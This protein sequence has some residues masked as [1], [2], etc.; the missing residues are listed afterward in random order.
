MSAPVAALLGV[1]LGGLLS[2]TTTYLLERRRE[3]G[4]SRAVQRLVLLELVANGAHA[5]RLLAADEWTDRFTFETAVWTSHRETAAKAASD[6]AWMMMALAYLA[7]GAADARRR[8]GNPLN[9]KDREVLGGVVEGVDSALEDAATS[10][11]DSDLEARRIRL[12]QAIA[13]SGKD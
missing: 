1:V 10:R 2:A 13:G 5:G 11:P 3:R 9:A 7:V 4:H 6:D 8:D 12:Y